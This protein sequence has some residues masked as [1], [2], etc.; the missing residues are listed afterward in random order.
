MGLDAVVYRNRAHIELGRD[1][2]YAKQDPRTGEVYFE[3]LIL[4]RKYDREREAVSRRLGNVAA[5]ADLVEQVVQLLGSDSF[6]AQKILYSGTHSGDSIPLK[7]I[8]ELAAELHAIRQSA[9]LSPLLGE[10]LNAFEELI[11]A[12]NDEGNPIVFV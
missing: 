10:F 1:A 2:E 3:D 4:S 8:P 7:D 5:V 12:A 9:R 6:I 11:K